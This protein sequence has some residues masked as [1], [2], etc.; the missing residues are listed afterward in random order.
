MVV[1][2][3]GKSALAVSIGIAE[4]DG[5][6]SA[7]FVVELIKVVDS[8]SAKT[9]PSRGLTETGD[10]TAFQKAVALCAPVE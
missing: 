5:S 4:N 1:K 7:L 10:Q 9:K 8:S 6:S 3:A 2:G